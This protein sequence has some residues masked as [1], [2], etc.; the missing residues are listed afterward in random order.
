MPDMADAQEKVII[1]EAAEALRIEYPN[2]FKVRNPVFS[3]SCGECAGAC[4][5][6]ESDRKKATTPL[7]PPQPHPTQSPSSSSSSSHTQVS[8]NCRLPHVNID[9][10]RDAIFK[11]NVV[12]RTG[13]SSAAQL[14]EWVKAKN[15]RIAEKSDAEWKESYRGRNADTVAKAVDKARA[16]NF[17]LGLEPN[18]LDYEVAEE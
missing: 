8:A 9:N 12:G 3:L 17:F 4:N 16:N 1:N 11:A 7:F 18:W 6:K 10:L 5:S 2:M 15:A 14:V 13:M